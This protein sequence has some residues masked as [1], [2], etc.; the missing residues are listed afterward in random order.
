M[1]QQINGTAIG[2]PCAVVLAN[3]YAGRTERTIILKE[4]QHNNSFIGRFIDDI[5]GV[6]DFSKKEKTFKEYFKR[7]NQTT[8]LEWTLEGPTDS[9]NFMDLNISLNN[10]RQL[11]FKTYQKP[12]SLYQYIPANSAHPPGVLKSIVYGRTR[13]YWL[14]NSTD[15]D[16]IHI[17]N[18]LTNRLLNQGY[19]K[20]S[21][22]KHINKALNKY[23]SQDMPNENDKDTPEKTFYYQI[24]YHRRGIQRKQ[25][26]QQY[27]K[28]IQPHLPFPLRIALY[29]PPNLKDLLCKSK[30]KSIPGNDPSDFLKGSKHYSKHHQKQTKQIE[31]V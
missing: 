5:I 28:H 24:T 15:A 21:L 31:F 3:L 20:P 29:R 1:F 11:V 19:T 13:K 26:Q 8:T 7:M 2:A 16:F 17:M 18:I 4:F 14:D 30:L 10:N 9:I 6:W 12:T 22:T 23:T 27:R 25:I